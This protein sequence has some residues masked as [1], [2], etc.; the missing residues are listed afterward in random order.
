MRAED[1][2]APLLE[3]DAAM[4]KGAFREIGQRSKMSVFVRIKP[5]PGVGAQGYL[6]EAK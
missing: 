5:T 6:S 2:D 4:A 1:R 3:R